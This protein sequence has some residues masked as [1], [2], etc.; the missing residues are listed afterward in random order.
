LLLIP[1]ESIPLTGSSHDA[2]AFDLN[3][4]STPKRLVLPSCIS[5]THANE[6]TVVFRLMGFNDPY[7]YDIVVW[8]IEKD[9][10]RIFRIDVRKGMSSWID[11]L[12]PG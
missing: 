9:F 1:S 10:S 5:F 11:R 4:T 8:N 3:N 6:S 2:F 12:S 7:I